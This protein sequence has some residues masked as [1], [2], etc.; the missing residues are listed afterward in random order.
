MKPDPKYAGNVSPVTAM[1]RRAE[2]KKKVD[3][4][5]VV[6]LAYRIVDE[7]ATPHSGDRTR[8][9][10]LAERVLAHAVVRLRPKVLEDERFDRDFEWG[11]AAL[12]PER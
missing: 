7:G 3:L 2:R 9:P 6:R 11:G 4:D 1:E 8:T 10:T 12:G 5:A